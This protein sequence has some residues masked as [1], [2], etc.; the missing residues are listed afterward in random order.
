MAATLGGY[1]R[2][3][4][5]WKLQERLANKDQLQVQK[6]IDSANI[7]LEIAEKDLENQDLQI[8]NSKTVDT[9]LHDKFTNQDLYSW[10]AGQVSA[11][12]FQAY[13]IAYDTAKR[14]ERAYRF[15][16]GLVSSN[17][18][19]FGCWDSQRKGLLAG[20]Q[21][22]LALKR[23]EQSYLELN[24]REYE[25]TKHVSLMLH[26][27]AVLIQLKQTGQCEVELPEA[28]FDADYPGHYMRRLKSVSL[29]IPCVVGP[30]TS[31]NCTLTLLSNK[32]RVKNI[33]G[34]QYD[35]LVD[36]EDDRFVTNFASL[37][38][39]ATSHGQNDSGMF[40]LN[41]RDERYLPF[42]GAGTIS[43]WRIELPR[44]TNAFDFSTLT[45]LVLH[46]KYT[47]REG[48]SM[49]RKAAIEARDTLLTNEDA[50]LARLFSSRHE[51]PDQWYRF[52][53]PK[54]TDAKQV[55]ELDLSPERFPFEF[56]GKEIQ[57]HRV[58]L[59][60]K[61]K[62]TNIP[63]Q[64]DTFVTAYQEKGAALTLSLAESPAQ[65]GAQPVVLASAPLDSAESILNGLA[66]ANIQVEGTVPVAWQ[67][68]TGDNE[69]AAIAAV[70]RKDV[71]DA[72]TA[73]TKHYRLKA[74]AIE[75]LF[76]L[77]HYTISAQVG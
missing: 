67:I 17:F 7:R 54:D 28:L 63:G 22:H 49:L 4:Q 43:R 76:I 59:F 58:Q 45:D 71:A 8:E 52:L 35:E 6:Q 70:L 3:W 23:M 30:Y 66:H 47:A 41:F 10:M 64:S 77:C 29:T 31:V 65:E 40:E 62:D 51:F 56:R 14:A 11:V 37:Q 75:D 73:G 44:E 34:S 13:K 72:V 42:E 1:D 57:I 55:L 2:R 69:I 15:E 74:E 38:S 9:F 24:R 60:L 46:L 61:F 19:Q 5:D 33:V 27:P 53:H 32:T 68:E 12:Y 26:N 50:P 18:I 36:E 39:I 25:I 20:E 48:G 16:L 21:L